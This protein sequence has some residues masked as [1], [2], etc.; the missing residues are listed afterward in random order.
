MLLAPVLVPV[1]AS[2]GI[3]EPPVVADDGPH[4]VEP[5]AVI[6]VERGSVSAEELAAVTAV[7]LA[8]AAAVRAA[9]EA[10]A[11]SGVR[12]AAAR[13]RVHG[14]AGPRAWTT[15]ARDLLAS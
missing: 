11:S 6:R 15:D 2:A 14:F 7:L 12:R 4:V 3:L 5:A 13:W 8:R 9:A 10:Q 1:A